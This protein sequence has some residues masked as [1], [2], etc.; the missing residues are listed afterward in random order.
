MVCIC[1][2]VTGSVICQNIKNRIQHQYMEEVEYKEKDEF[3]NERGGY[4]LNQTL[5]YN[6]LQYS[7]TMDYKVEINGKVFYAGGW[8]TF[9]STNLGP[10]RPVINIEPRNTYGIS[11]MWLPGQLPG[12]WRSV[13]RVWRFYYLLYPAGRRVR[14]HH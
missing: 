13:P 7:K 12:V 6:S 4:K 8:A 14:D 9:S 2:T 3:F 5:D 11:C 1:I 10:D